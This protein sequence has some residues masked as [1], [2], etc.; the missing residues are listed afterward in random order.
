MDFGNCHKSIFAHSDSIMSV[1]CVRDTHYFF[2]GSK[3]KTIKYWDGDTFQLI[4]EFN[5]CM[6][7]VWN[8]VVSE[9]GDFFIAA[10]NDKAMRM[11]K[12]NKDQV[13]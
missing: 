4:L 5:E 8:L 12:Q 1:V 7:E 9:V 13:H 11:W 10:S 6:A 2:T 3:D